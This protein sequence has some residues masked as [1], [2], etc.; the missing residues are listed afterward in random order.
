MT[1]GLIRQQM[2]AAQRGRAAL[3]RS[4]ELLPAVCYYTHVGLESLQHFLKD[5]KSGV[6]L[7][8]SAFP[9][10]KRKPLLHGSSGRGQTRQ[11]Q[12]TS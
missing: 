6:D 7:I 9:V 12:P 5:T 11:V 2:Q 4:F 3:K 1:R 10:L 8:F